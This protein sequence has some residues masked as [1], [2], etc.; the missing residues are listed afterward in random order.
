M[1]PRKQITYACRQVA[2]L[3]S[4]PFVKTPRPLYRISCRRSETESGN[5]KDFPR[6][7][8]FHFLTGGIARHVHVATAWVEWTENVTG[9]AGDLFGRRHWGLGR[10]VSRRAWGR[11]C[12]FRYRGRRRFR[13]WAWLCAGARLILRGRRPPL[14]LRFGG[15][16][17][18]P[19]RSHRIG[20]NGRCR[21]GDPGIGLPIDMAANIIGRCIE[22]PER[23]HRNV[24]R[25]LT[26]AQY[27]KSEKKA[28]SRFH[29]VYLAAILFA[30]RDFVTSATKSS[31]CFSVV[32]Q[33][34][35]NR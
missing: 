34:H 2:D 6:I 19:R 8:I 20:G 35:I 10:G 12:F 27:K 30:A 29:A 23:R 31:I 13:A 26:A 14:G 28:S 9:L 17:G 24:V 1:I 4:K 5:K 21:R 7:G 18:S 3:F 15:R 22:D 33:A 16:Y 11:F 32:D 25:G